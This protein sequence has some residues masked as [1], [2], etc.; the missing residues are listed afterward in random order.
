MF[1]WLVRVLEMIRF[2]HT[3]FALPFALLSAVIAWHVRARESVPTG[4]SSPLAD[5][6]TAIRWQELVAI[7]VCMV[8]ARSAAMAFNRLV[9]RHIDARNPRTSNRHLPAGLLSVWGVTLFTIVSSLGFVAATLLLLPN[10]LPLM[11]SVPVL[12]FLMAYSFTKR[13]IA[14]A[15]GWLGASLMLAPISA[16]IAVRGE[17][18][19]GQ[20]TDL[21]PGLVL[22]IAVLFWVS[23]FDII[24]ACLDVDFDTAQQLHSAP[25]RLGVVPALRVAALCH[26][27]MVLTLACLPLVDWCGGP[28]LDLH[29]IYGT[30]V[31]AVAALLVYE[32]ALVRPGDLTRVNV[33]FFHV[34]SVVSMGLFGI[35]TLDLI[36]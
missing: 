32:H 23:G 36:T 10:R 6:L 33:A 7:L 25:S 19:G 9:D 2:S 20:P 27:G 3:I 12:L 31:G 17:H 16:W 29:W 5:L 30:G 18:V 14:W 8:T 34:N 11:L 13:F 24:Y 15:H 21:L 22:G 35:V 28:V 4:P 1:I 26:L